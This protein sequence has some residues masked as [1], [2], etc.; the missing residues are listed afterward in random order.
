MALWCRGLGDRL[1]ERE[2]D[3]ID[4]LARSTLWREPT[5]TQAKWLKSIFLR[6]GGEI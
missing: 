5:E 3:F 1:T 6:L 2:H 4:K